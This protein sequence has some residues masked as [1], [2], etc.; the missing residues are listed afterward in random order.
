AVAAPRRRGRPRKSPLPPVSPGSSLVA[1][2]EGAAQGLAENYGA[3]VA[4]AAYQDTLSRQPLV[5]VSFCLRAK[6]EFGTRVRVVGGHESLGTWQVESAPELVWGEGDQWRA[7]IR[8][9]AGAIVEYKYVLLESGGGVRAWQSGANNVLAVKL[10]EERIELFDTWQ[11]NPDQA[12]VVSD[13]GAAAKREGRL[14]AWA[15]EMM[16]QL[17][18]QRQEMRRMSL[19][20]AGSQQELKEARERAEFFRGQYA[21]KEAERKEVAA[22]LAEAR[23]LNTALE[24][25]LLDT[26]GALKEA[27]ETASAL[28]EQVDAKGAAIR[29][30]RRS[31]AA[32]EEADSNDE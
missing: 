3:A 1:A 8:L 28:L 25:Q 30:K 24:S 32:A 9:P 21:T 16:S 6:L 23:A 5:D 17:S 27:I 13:G 12:L 26:T 4:L 22:Q 19:E 7:K 31:R 20:L 11:S 18:A 10:S 14:M 2:A 15:G 29:S